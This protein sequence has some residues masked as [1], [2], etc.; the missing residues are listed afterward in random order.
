MLASP[1]DLV[2]ILRRVADG[3]RRAF[4]E[5]YRATSLKLF[6]IIFRILKRQEPAEEVLQEVYCKIWE[7]VGSFDPTR[8]SPITWMAT[9]ARNRALDEV[10]KREPNLVANAADVYDVVDPGKMPSEQVEMSEELHRL[11]ACLEGLEE[12]RRAAIK[13]AYL[14]GFSRKELA[15]QFDQP[16]GTIKTWLYRGL[17]QLKDCL[18]S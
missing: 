2:D 11:E 15:E 8:A 16:V 4:A 17:K 9:I 3:D 13:L 6:G 14:D 5:L 12:D 18:G 1:S 7:N 10:R